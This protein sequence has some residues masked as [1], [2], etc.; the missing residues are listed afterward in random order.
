M[1]ADPKLLEA[2]RRAFVLPA[3]GGRLGRLTSLVAR[4]AS[5]SIL[6][7]VIQ[8]LGAFLVVRSLAKTEYAW[9][10]LAN[11][12]V[13]ALGMF[14]VT[15]ISTG[16]MPMAGEAATDRLRL[17]TV[18]ASAARFRSLLLVFGSLAGIPVFAYTL[19]HSECS[20]LKTAVL[21]AAAVV[22][23][24]TAITAQML[25]TPLSLARRYNVPQWETIM[26][27][28]L[29]L[30][31]IV[32][33][34]AASMADSVSVMLVTVLAPLPT[35]F[36]YLLPKA[37]EHAAFEQ[38]SD[39]AVAA[40]LKKHFFVGLPTSLTY[41]FEAQIA[42]FIVGWMGNI[43]KVADLGA[44]SRVALILQVPLA[45]ASGILLPRMSAEQN[46]QRLWKMWLGCSGL[47]IAMGLVI[48]GGGWLARNPLLFLLGPEYAGL[49]N[50]LV[51]Y[52]AFQAFSFFVTVSGMPIQ[53]KGWVRHSWARPVMVFGSQAL[54]ACFL[55]LS[56]VSGAIGLMWAGSI[57][58]TLM[59][60]FLLINGWRGRASI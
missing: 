8:M 21:V 18:L 51:L 38:P 23:V 45:I 33:L 29:R 30:A 59:N 31:L 60:A 56:T 55:D 32:A 52:L 4:Y 24:I 43:D 58:N 26:N 35:L 46:Q 19:L 49:Q 39:P 22:S 12:L 53:S 44:I 36:W 34:V 48:V 54:A 17:G 3:L 20:P 28:V 10:S 1:E 50:E 27:S 13:G 37:R 14:T 41:L 40:R 42:A 9:Y 47:S 6:G 7:R 15:G 2:P 5:L 57:G 16:L 25:S 11:N